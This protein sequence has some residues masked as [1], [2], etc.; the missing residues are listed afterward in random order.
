MQESTSVFVTH[1]RKR[2]QH[3]HPVLSSE[4]MRRVH[5][6]EVGQTGGRVCRSPTQDVAQLRRVGIN[7]VP[8]HQELRVFKKIIHKHARNIFS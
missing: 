6:A 4:R 8:R 5:A 1:W 7:R 2:A 3:L